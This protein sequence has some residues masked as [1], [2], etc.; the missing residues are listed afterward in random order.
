LLDL[1]SIPLSKN[2]WIAIFQK[3]V[4]VLFIESLLWGKPASI[5]AH[6]W[7]FVATAQGCLKSESVGKNPARA[8]FGRHRPAPTG[9]P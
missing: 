9:R 7:T 5:P 8:S 3:S 2:I 6:V 1:A 4:Y